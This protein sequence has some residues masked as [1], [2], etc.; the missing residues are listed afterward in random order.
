[1]KT[2]VLLCT[3]AIAALCGC[4]SFSR[5][6][7]A[8]AN[9]SGVDVAF[10]ID[11]YGGGVYEL[12]KGKSLT[13][14]LYSRP[15]LTFAESAAAAEANH[16][17]GLCALRVRSDSGMASVVITD[18]PKYTYTL[19]N[20]SQTDVTVTERNG[21]AGAA[22]GNPHPGEITV[23]AG[24]SVSGIPVYTPDP[25]FVCGDESAELCGVTW[26]P[27]GSGSGE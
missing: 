24:G 17:A 12:E 4:D 3:A 5:H 11:G 10:T 26:E 19:T 16:A 9:E 7:V 13:L 20:S 23:P 14:N 15:R 22:A 1:M 25:E 2:V 27:D 6:D 8:I 18:M 21:L